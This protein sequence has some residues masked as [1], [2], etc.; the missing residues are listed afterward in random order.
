M[1]R[2]PRIAIIGAGPAGL[3]LARLLTLA[4][5]PTTI[6]ER[7]ESPQTQGGSLDLHATTGLAAVKA[8]NLWPEFEA[9]A[10]YDGSFTQITDQYLNP[11][12]TVRPNPKAP[13]PEIDCSVLVNLLADSLPNET[14]QWGKK[15]ERVET[16]RDGVL[17]LIFDGHDETPQDFDLVVGADGAWSKVRLAM[18]G[19]DK[20][21]WKPTYTG[22]GYHQLHISNPPENAPLIHKLINGG[23]LFAHA[24]GRKVALQ[25]DGTGIA[26]AAFA[27]DFSEGYWTKDP[28][29]R[30]EER[31][32]RL[33]DEL[34][35]WHPLIRV[36]VEA[37]DVKFDRRPLYA[38]P[39][40]WKSD[41]QR[42]LTIIG[43]AAHL[44]APFAGEGVNLAMDDAR[45]LA[46]AIVRAAREVQGQEKDEQLRDALDREV[47]AFEA[48]MVE[49][50]TPVQQLAA[51][52]T[53][54]WMFTPC[55]PGSVVADTTAMMIQRE[56][57]SR[58]RPV[59]GVGI[60]AWFRAKRFIGKV[61]NSLWQTA[62][63]LN[64]IIRIE[65][66]SAGTQSRFLTVKDSKQTSLFSCNQYAALREDA[67]DGPRQYDFT[68]IGSQG[69]RLS[70]R[71]IYYLFIRSRATR[72]ATRSRRREKKQFSEA[73]R[74]THGGTGDMQETKFG[75]AEEEAKKC[76]QGSHGSGAAVVSTMDQLDQIG[77]YV[78]R[79]QRVGIA[80]AENIVDDGIPTF[81]T[82][83]LFQTLAVPFR[84]ST[85]TLCY[86]WIISLVACLSLLAFLGTTRAEESE[87][88]KVC[89]D[90]WLVLS[91]SWAAAFLSS[92]PSSVHIC[93]SPGGWAGSNPFNQT[94]GELNSLRETE[95]RKV[96][97]RLL[98]LLLSLTP[99]TFVC[100]WHVARQRPNGAL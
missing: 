9:A 33:Q 24:E 98:L 1:P 38:L 40:G 16:S 13:R 87:T 82:G 55:V 35:E 85:G 58:L 2:L 68:A 45:R 80:R 62:F 95:M 21:A 31:R 32:L 63:A 48:G 78:I 17:H 90:Y 88:H 100:S 23:A 27:A 92:P 72:S 5:I 75:E 76:R 65:W 77:I 3:T 96:T 19:G 11:Y 83:R 60:K 12:L 14:I 20:Q 47:A 74:P 37:A 99:T 54:L 71:A 94:Q 56:V 25:Q 30:D 66:G 10:R 51:D 44:M 22:V 64:D 8:A 41:H 84:D 93:M 50:A 43:D 28:E 73:R 53:R 6:F 86:A 97:K 79:V 70:S 26:V 49:R 59:L 15:L 89:L 4:S 29:I 36:A 42:G 81:G 67:V 69:R 52:L 91:T 39:P 18:V 7:A 57:H 46:E 61:V 34:N